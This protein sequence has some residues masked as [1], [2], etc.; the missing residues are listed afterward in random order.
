MIILA[1]S[2][3]SSVPVLDIHEKGHGLPGL[4]NPT[5]FMLDG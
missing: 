3:V 1:T 2:M 4:A 5:W